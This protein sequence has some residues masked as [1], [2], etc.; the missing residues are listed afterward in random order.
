M[1]VG[2]K[3]RLGLGFMAAIASLA[4]YGKQKP[5]SGKEPLG[6]YGMPGGYA[7]TSPIFMGGVQ[8][9]NKKSNRKRLSHN[10]KLKRRR[11]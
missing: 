2:M 8:Q 10:A 3:S 5:E 1:K 9:K 6:A 11:G 4:G 7:I